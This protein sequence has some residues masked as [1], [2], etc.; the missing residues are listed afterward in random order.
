ML[1]TPST[2]RTSPQGSSAGGEQQQRTPTTQE[3]IGMVSQ[4]QESITALEQR[5]QQ[6]EDRL[7]V[8][9][10]KVRPLELFDGS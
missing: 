6:L 1:I 4:L 9:S 5:N 7:A 3:L 10:V 8:K 2:P